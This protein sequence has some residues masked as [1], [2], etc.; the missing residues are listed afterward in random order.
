[1][2]TEA[3]TSPLATPPHRR[4]RGRYANRATRNRTITTVC[5]A[6][7]SPTRS[8]TRLCVPCVRMVDSYRRHHRLESG[9]RDASLQV[10]LA[11]RLLRHHPMES[12]EPWMVVLRMNRMGRQRPRLARRHPSRL[13]SRQ[14]PECVNVVVMMGSQQKFCSRRCALMWRYAHG[15]GPRQRR[16]LPSPSS[17]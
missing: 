1:M 4:K 11:K 12:N 10:E 7:Q 8:T 16:A 2:T 15:T 13:Y 14:C 6:C 5:E 9:Q 3:V 17:P